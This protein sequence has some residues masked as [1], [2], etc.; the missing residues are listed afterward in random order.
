VF[1]PGRADAIHAVGAP[2]HVELGSSGS[3]P[4]VPLTPE[5]PAL[6]ASL[7]FTVATRTGA[8]NA[9]PTVDLTLA[10]DVD[11]PKKAAGD[12]PPEPS[13]VSATGKVTRAGLAT[14]Q[15]GQLGAG[16]QGEVAK[17]KGSQLRIVLAPKGGVQSVSLQL[18]KAATPELEHV[19]A[20]AVDALVAFDVA[21]PAA[22]VGVGAAWIAR[23]RESHSGLDVVVYRM[24]RVTA[25]EGDDV[26]LSVEV[27]LYASGPDVR[28]PGMPPGTLK[29]MEAIGQ[30]E[31]VLKKGASVAHQGSLQ[32]RL[33]LGLE[34]QGQPSAGALGG[35]LPVLFQTQVDMGKPAK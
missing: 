17:M 10:F 20:G 19:L 34:P 16:V 11:K 35:L 2:V 1:E 29:Q 6:P 28:K 12:S 3:E 18:A 9:L 31:F 5:Q 33:M 21:V 4:R 7:G 27:R 26:K 13:V 25:I 22:P 23:N 15:P 32:Q 30:G 24:Y 14:E 8:R